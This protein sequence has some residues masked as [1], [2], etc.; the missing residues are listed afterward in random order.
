MQMFFNSLDRL[1]KAKKMI[2]LHES[3]NGL[4]KPSV[5][6]ITGRTNPTDR[7]RAKA[8]IESGDL[9]II[10]VCG[11]FCVGTDLPRC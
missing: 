11:I 7:E 9:D 8:Q 2:E 10:I 4:R 1:D 5:E 3:P 6:I